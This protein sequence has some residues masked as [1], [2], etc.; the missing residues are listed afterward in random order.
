MATVIVGGDV[1]PVGRSEILFRQRAAE[2]MFNGL[3]SEFTQADF[4]VVNLECPLTT[5]GSPVD[6]DGRA[7]KAHIDCAEGLRAAHI[8][9]VNLA[10]NHILDYGES[11]LESTITA[12]QQ[13]GIEHF[14]AGADSRQAGQILVWN[15]SGLRVGFL[16]AAEREFNMS[17]RDTWGANPLD[18]VAMA[19]SLRAHRHEIDFLVALVHGG[20][21]YYP[22]PTPR[23]QQLCRFL[24]EEGAH[25][26]ICQ[27]SHCPGSYEE[28]EGALI[29]YGQGNLLFDAP[30]VQKQLWHQGF[31]VTL[32]PGDAYRNFSYEFVPYRQ[33]QEKPGAHRLSDESAAAFVAELARRRREVEADGFVE[34]QWNDYCRSQKY[35]YS[36]RLRGHGRLLRLLN[37]KIHFTDWLV[38]KES[39]L[40][41]RNVIECETHREVLE[42]L[43]KEDW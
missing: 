27:H 29:V 37:R 3:L 40:D 25:A 15:I 38:S 12:C 8:R 6:K 13:A 41:Q 11:G 10:N 7:L 28:Y 36:S 24:V 43:W 32:H 16:G 42:T 9:A 30:R 26:V 34:R 20:R 19:R 14:G 5:E 4:T 33:S 17:A 23:L 2:A 21:E 35:L 1:C 31:L 39:K 18:P 22:Y